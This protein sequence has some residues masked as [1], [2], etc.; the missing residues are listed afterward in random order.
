MFLPEA[1]K[2]VFGRGMVYFDR[3]ADGTLVG[4]GERYIG[5]TTGF[6]L[7]RETDVVTRSVSIAGRLHNRSPLTIRERNVGRFVTDHIDIENVAM[8]FG[9]APDTTGMAPVGLIAES[10]VVKRGRHYQL[11]KSR[12]PTGVLNVDH[13]TFSIAGTPLDPAGKILVDEP[14]GR[15]HILPDAAIANGTT[16]TVNFEWRRTAST[17]VTAKP[18]RLTG[19]LRFVSTNV[20]GPQKNYFFPLVD[21]APT[22]EASLKGDEWQSLQF[23]FEARS[24][25][26]N[27]EQLYILET[28][29]GTYT[30]DEEGIIDGG[31][32][33]GEFSYWDDQLNTIINIDLPA[34]T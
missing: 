2:I 23:E 32:E 34:H 20:V 7:N 21:I 24:K 14:Q 22:A 3:F 17:T 6:G 11:G 29:P 4:E 31:L 16:L 33:L 18:K 10:F 19:A 30:R 27:V 25:L 13:V 9:G 15:I 8:W 5:N 12:F 26:P 28:T 1:T